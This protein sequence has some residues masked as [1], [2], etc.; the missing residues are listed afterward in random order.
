MLYYTAFVVLSWQFDH[1]R[2]DMPCCI[3]KRSANRQREFFDL[4][5]FCVQDSYFYGHMG[6]YLNKFQVGG[7]TNPSEKYARQIGSFHQIGVK[8]HNIWVAT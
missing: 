1:K 8:I 6:F 4:K 5:G 7:W 2:I 3:K